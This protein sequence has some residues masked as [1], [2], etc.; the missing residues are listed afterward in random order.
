MKKITTLILLVAAGLAHAQSTIQI[1][2]TQYGIVNSQTLVFY[3]N[4]GGSVT[5]SF[6][7]TATQ[8]PTPSLTIHE[9]D[10]QVSPAVATSFQAGGVHYAINNSQPFDP[11]VW[12][13]FVAEYY[14]NAP[15]CDTSDITYVFRN[16]TNPADTAWIRFIYYCVGGPAGVENNLPEEQVVISPNPASN[17]LQLTFLSPQQNSHLEVYNQLGER[18]DVFQISAFSSAAVVDV[19]RFADG[20][21]LFRIVNTNGLVA[22]KPVVI[23][24]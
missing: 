11:S 20:I 9:Y 24:H 12:P 19:N 15:D 10:W 17:Q 4:S 6:S 8:Q 23:K 7:V 2:S 3:V 5:T 22:Q 21:Y 18:V 13:D 14:L 1:S 16:T